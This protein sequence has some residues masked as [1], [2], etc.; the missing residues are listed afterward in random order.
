MSFEFNNGRFLVLSIE[1]RLRSNQKHYSPFKGFFRSYTKFF[2]LATES[3]VIG[4]RSHIRGEDIYLYPLKVELDEARLMLLAFLKR[5]KKLNTQSVF[6]NTLIGNCLTD[7][8]RESNRFNHWHQ[9]LDY[10]II[11]PGYADR[12]LY[13]MGMIDS[14]LDFKTLRETAR[15][16][17]EDYSIDDKDYSHRIRSGYAIS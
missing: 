17:P 5:A 7:L 9:W 2:V 3:D 6:Y 10:R 12:L 8:L 16:K 4:L 14:K 15:V 13:K 11:F 1:S